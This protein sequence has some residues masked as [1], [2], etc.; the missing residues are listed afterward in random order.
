M[1]DTI[2]S[3]DVRRTRDDTSTCMYK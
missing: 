2:L 3:H 1:S